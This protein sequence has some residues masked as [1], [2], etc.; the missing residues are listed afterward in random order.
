MIDFRHRTWASSD[1]F[2]PR[3]F[4]RPFVRFSQI[5]ASSGI[6]ILVSALIALVVAN[7]PWSDNYFSILETHLRIEFFGF[8]FEQ[9]VL[10]LINDGLMTLFFFVVGLEIKREAVLGDLRDP[11]AAA[12]PDPPGFPTT[13]FSWG[14]LRPGTS[15]STPPTPESGCST[16]T[17]RTT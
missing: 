13:P 11:K 5:E 8:Q 6:A 14:W 2:V 7:S 9:S 10:H 16:A 12:L 15:S 4:I 17:F 3:T 1:R